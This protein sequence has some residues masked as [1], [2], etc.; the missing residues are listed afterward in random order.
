VW[1]AFASRFAIKL[2]QLRLFKSFKISGEQ[3]SMEGLRAFHEVSLSLMGGE[4]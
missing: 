1:L 2:Y 4:I 3:R